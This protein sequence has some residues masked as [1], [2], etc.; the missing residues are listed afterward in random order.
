M[1]VRLTMK[2]KSLKIIGFLFLICLCSCGRKSIINFLKEYNDEP[3]LTLCPS[4]NFYYGNLNAQEQVFISSKD[5]LTLYYDLENP[6]DYI[7]VPQFADYALPE[8]GFQLVDLQT[9]PQ[10]QQ[11][12]SSH[13]KS[14]Q[15]GELKI[16]QFFKED[17]E[18]SE[19]SGKQKISFSLPKRFLQLYDLG[20]SDTKKE[21]LV[22]NLLWGQNY[23]DKEGKYLRE[24]SK[25]SIE[26]Y[27]NE[28]P[29]PIAAAGILKDASNK[30]ILAFDV[31]S[32]NDIFIGDVN[33]HSD[34]KK[35]KVTSTLLSADGSPI[36]YEY[37]VTPPD[38]QNDEFTFTPSSSAS[39]RIVSND[40]YDDAW[41]NLDDTK[42]WNN[43]LSS[44]YIYTDVYHLAGFDG[45]PTFTLTFIDSCGLESS[46]STDAEPMPKL[47]P[48]TL[49]KDDSS[50]NSTSSNSL[51]LES[52]DDSVT[53]TLKAPKTDTA[54]NNVSKQVSI[55]CDL[56]KEEGGNFTWKSAYFFDAGKDGPIEL[57][58]GTWKIKALAKAGEY[59][60][61]D[62]VEYILTVTG[63][64]TPTPPVITEFYVSKEGNDTTGDGTTDKPF[65]TLTRALEK[66]ND[67]D[68]GYTIY[69][70]DAVT[71]TAKQ[72]IMLNTINA[73]SLTISGEDPS[74]VLKGK[75]SDRVL[76]I[77]ANDNTNAPKF[78]LKD[79]NIETGVKGMGIT[80]NSSADVDI[81]GC[82][83]QGNGSTSVSGVGLNI[84]KA[85]V[86]LN[87]T[88]VR[89]FETSDTSGG[90]GILV[91]NEATL[92]M[93]G[94]T[95]VNTCKATANGAYG[96][97]ILVSNKSKLYIGYTRDSDE[98]PQETSFTGEITGN[99]ASSGGG[100]ALSGGATCLM[101][102]GIISENKADVGSSTKS[103]GGMYLKDS[104]TTFT[105]EGG[106]IKNNEANSGYGGGVAVSTDA[107][108]TMNGGVIGDADAISVATED[109]H[110]NK[111][112][113]GAGVYVSNGTFIHKGGTIGYNYAAYYGS[114]GSLNLINARGGGVAL[115]SSNMGTRVA[116]Y[117]MNG[118]NATISYNGAGSAGGGIFMLT[119]NNGNKTC[120]LKS[121]TI[122]GNEAELGG[123]IYNTRENCVISMSG[124]SIEKNNATKDGGAIYIS[125][126][127]L[128]LT[129]GSI[130][131]NTATISGDGV[132]LAYGFSGNFTIGNNIEFL[133]HVS[134]IYCSNL[135]PTS[136]VTSY[137]TISDNLTK[138]SSSNE[139]NLKLQLSDPVA[140]T[141]SGKVIATNSVTTNLSDCFDVNPGYWKLALDN[142]RYKLAMDINKVTVAQIKE[143]LEDSTNTDV[144]TTIHDE[145]E[146]VG[147]F[148][149][150]K[151]Q[152]LFL[153][154]SDDDNNL[155]D[156]YIA[157]ELVFDGRDNIIYSFSGA[158]SST[159]HTFTNGTFTFDSS[160]TF[161]LVDFD[162]DGND[163]IQ[164]DWDK[165]NNSIYVCSRRDTTGFYIFK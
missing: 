94:S 145:P 67:S 161:H 124:G 136:T 122:K 70:K 147:H 120:E 140:V 141:N 24:F 51:T 163:D 130:K 90:A 81:T 126:G 7:V 57:K 158:R 66:V 91:D 77:T 46:F 42:K 59:R 164:I 162:K 79:L 125:A 20:R 43:T 118:T 105:M 95:S 89:N 112:C 40:D 62:S 74:S 75:D 83:I 106:M 116:Y 148:T 117:I 82:T 5:D 49:Y 93:A 150:T 127:E 26:F 137:F 9:K 78:Y 72:D 48:P 85:H 6:H 4:D 22:I 27:V 88:K 159:P 109:N 54:G 98:T 18:D 56:Y 15:L 13:Y 21:K 35:L 142:D 30:L 34:I 38:T 104:G 29:I 32:N 123:G 68:K 115:N 114:P 96:G 1:V 132:C 157:F 65:A 17:S 3:T 33:F 153:Q 86:I 12:S 138:H 143:V 133:G 156:F 44:F 8:F 97:G 119:G 151:T 28:K 64:N 50:L 149:G 154:F 128:S 108:F 63:D 165:D 25:P 36:N 102:A 134:D 139:I 92:F 41:L 19:D 47:N 76:V 52:G 37:D 61:S 53:V 58:Q 121:G 80:I 39:N 45:N 103:G 101:N 31:P 11:Y 113:C 152:R 131:N 107:T 111:A 144:K 99:H 55:E 60:T 73:K 135:D 146:I 16:S 160:N 23:N 87:N 110:S 129:G 84:N 69:I 10:Q 14:L 2:H 155:I 71:L 100:V